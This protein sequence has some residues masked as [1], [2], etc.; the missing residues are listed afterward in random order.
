MTNKFVDTGNFLTNAL[1]TYIVHTK[2]TRIFNDK[3]KMLFTIKIKIKSNKQFSIYF[4]SIFLLGS[5][6]NKIF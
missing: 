1:Y 5:L 4:F 2:D 3:N 6:M